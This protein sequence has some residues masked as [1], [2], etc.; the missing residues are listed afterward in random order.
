MFEKVYLGP[1]ARGEHERVRRTVRGLFEHYLE[2]PAEV[3]ESEPG[4]DLPQRVTDY[5][6]GMTDRFCIASF[7]ALALPEETHL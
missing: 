1:E 4:A 6:A 5:L 3:P 7:R 2:D